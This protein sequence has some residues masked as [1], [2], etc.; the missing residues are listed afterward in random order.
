MIFVPLVTGMNTL[1]S[2]IIYLLTSSLDGIIAVT[3]VTNVRF[4]E[5]HVDIK[6]YI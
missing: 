5:Y 4:V 3:N 2:L 6:C 1:Q